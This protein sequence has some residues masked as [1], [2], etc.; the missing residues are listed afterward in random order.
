MF[1]RYS[2]KEITIEA[3][4]KYNIN[5]I[6]AFV[7]GRI[8][9]LIPD[10]PLP[11]EGPVGTDQGPVRALVSQFMYG[12]SG[13]DGGVHAVTPGVYNDNGAGIDD[14]YETISA[15]KML[16]VS[17][18]H[19]YNM[20]A[21]G[22]GPL[23]VSFLGGR[24][25]SN[26]W[27]ESGKSNELKLRAVDLKPDQSVGISRNTP[28][29]LNERWRM[30]ITNGKQPDVWSDLKYACIFIKPVFSGRTILEG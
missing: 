25:M 12:S 10:V 18:L 22:N 16:A 29:K 21:L 15:G 27:S 1:S 24:D 8:E 7:A 6:A 5:D 28:P 14:Q 9:R 11:N 20:N 19:G 26:D 13:T 4:R 17:Q 2:G 23:Q 30:R 3:C